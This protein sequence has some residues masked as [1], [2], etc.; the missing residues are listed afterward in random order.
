MNWQQLESLLLEHTEAKLKVSELG[1][2]PINWLSLSGW[3]D[4]RILAIGGHDGFVAQ[5]G[6]RSI[7][8]LP[9]TD[10]AYGLGDRYAKSRIAVKDGDADLDFRDQAIEAPHHQWLAQ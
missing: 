2:G 6:L 4:S 10:L 7:S 3:Y 5:I 9:Q 1:S 8:P